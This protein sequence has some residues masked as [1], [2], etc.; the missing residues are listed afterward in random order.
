MITV[1]NLAA[2][3]TAACFSVVSSSAGAKCLLPSEGTSVD[4][5]ISAQ[6]LDQIG[7][8]PSGQIYEFLDF[9]SVT[10]RFGPTEDRL[11]VDGPALKIVPMTVTLKAKLNSPREFILET[12]RKQLP[13]VGCRESYNVGYAYMEGV[14]AGHLKFQAKINHTDHSCDWPHFDQGSGWM[15]VTLHL[16]MESVGLRDYALRTEVE[17]GAAHGGDAWSDLAG[18]V[19]APIDIVLKI[20]DQKTLT[21]ALKQPILDD[22]EERADQQLADVRLFLETNVDLKSVSNLVG[23]SWPAFHEVFVRRLLNGPNSGFVTT[24]G[25]PFVTDAKVTLVLEKIE[26]PKDPVSWVRR[27]IACSLY[28]TV[29]VVGSASREI[30]T[31]TPNQTH[32]VKPGENL[33]DI[34]Q[35]YLGSADFLRYVKSAN[36]LDDPNLLQPGDEIIVPSVKPLLAEGNYVVSL[37]DTWWSIAKVTYGDALLYDEL[38]VANGM[39]SRAPLSVGTVLK[40]PPKEQLAAIEGL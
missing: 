36:D 16:F 4:I 10:F 17:R 28:D 23:D 32:V 34:T 13:P 1:R 25:T 39:R 20:F 8:S 2:L 5:P 22:V 6:L 15:M 9:N 38:A 37:G 19:F 18:I 7:F 24:G 30:S 33:S 40:L 21:D 31:G 27:D 3:L 14:D 29:G 12:I 35:A 11:L 26:D